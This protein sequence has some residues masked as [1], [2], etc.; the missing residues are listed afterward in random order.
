MGSDCRVVGGEGY[1]ER[2]KQNL[3]KR[4]QS[5]QKDALKGLYMGRHVG[6]FFFFYYC[7]EQTGDFNRQAWLMLLIDLS[8]WAKHRMCLRLSR[9]G[10]FWGYVLLHRHNLKQ[11]K[12]KH[13]SVS[14]KYFQYWMQAKIWSK[15]LHITTAQ[16]QTAIFDFKMGKK[17]GDK[18]YDGSYHT[19]CKLWSFSRRM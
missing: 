11:R 12:K 6:C 15:T 2:T 4:G 10:P 7:F 8:C 16:S 5:L 17:Q 14:H 9:R 19:A 18:C 13:A 3:G 1:W